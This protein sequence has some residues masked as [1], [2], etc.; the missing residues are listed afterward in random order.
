MKRARTYRKAAAGFTLLE[1]TIALSIFAVVGYGLAVAVDVGKDSQSMVIRESEDHRTMRTVVKT[2]A[3]ELRS[4]AD[5]QVTVTVLADGNHQL[6]F[7]VP[8]V[9]GG[10]STWGVYDRRLGSDAAS[11]NQAGW[12]VQYTVRNGVGV[13]GGVNRQLVRQELDTALAVQREEV[14]ADGLRA[15]NAAPRGF[16][17]VKN[18]DMWE[19]TL[20][21]VGQRAGLAGITQVF[22]VH[23]RN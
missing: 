18:G 4:S 23:A 1:S 9:A 22:H 15:G 6:R 17:V 11:Q 20:S 10:V 16:T 19:I 3:D 8:V 12:T 13:D 2:L 14:L 7:M 5:D 21:T